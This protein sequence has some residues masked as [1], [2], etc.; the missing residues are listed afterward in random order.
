VAL[1]LGIFA[2]GGY[3]DGARLVFG[4][5]GVA[6]AAAAVFLDGRGALREP[7]VLVLLALA[8]VGALSALWTLGDP[9]R[10]LRWALVTAGYAGV[11]LAAAAA[12]RRRGGAGALAGG[13]AAVAAAAG[14]TGLAAAVLF[15]AP[16]AE[17]VAGVW[18]PGG[19][20]EYAPALA[21]LQVSAL[22]ALMAGMAH[23][24]RLLAGAAAAGMAIAGACVALSA[25]RTALALAVL[26][27]G[28]GMAFGADRRRSGAAVALGAA[29]GAAMALFAGEAVANGAAVQPRRVAALLLVVLLAAPVWL[30]I[31]DRVPAGAGRGVRPAHAAAALL[32]L[33]A[34]AGAFAFGAQ[35]GRGAGPQSGFL[36]GRSVTWRAAAETFADRP[37]LGAGADAF[38]VGSIGHQ[39]GQTVVFAHDLPLELAAELGVAGLVLA[40]AL[41]A[42]AGRL[43]WRAGGSR[44]AWLFGPAVFA[45]LAASLVDWPWHLAGSGAVWALAAGALAGSSRMPQS[46]KEPEGLFAHSRE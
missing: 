20:L 19:P 8:A 46:P 1:A 30:A 45:F 44:E 7:L 23:R 35:A 10:S 33:A 13:L 9:A 39:R 18:R 31:R 34:L 28:A 32:V 42:A 27:A 24:S 2:D 25:S 29:A 6:A 16:Y 26:V 5:A 37:L 36:H 22:P 43:L 14:A 15:A 41:Y 21:L 40:V 17:R 11:A 38:L 4:C 3:G 12:A